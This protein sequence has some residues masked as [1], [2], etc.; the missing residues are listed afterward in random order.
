MKRC[1]DLLRILKQAIVA[2]FIVPSEH[3][4]GEIEENREIPQSGDTIIPQF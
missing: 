3:P 4:P 1:G 2:Y